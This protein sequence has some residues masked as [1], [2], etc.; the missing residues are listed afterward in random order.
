MNMLI[1]EQNQHE[2]YLNSREIRCYKDTWIEPRYVTILLTD[3]SLVT[4]SVSS[5]GEV[6]DEW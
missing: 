2:G 4:V 5:D 1:G 6:I 3:I